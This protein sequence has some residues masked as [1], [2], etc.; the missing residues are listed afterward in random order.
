MSADPSLRGR[1]IAWSPH[2]GAQEAFLSCPVFEVLLEGERGSGK[3]DVLLMD[4]AQFVDRGFGPAWRGVLFRRTYDELKDVIAK[5]EHWFPRIWPDATYNRVEHYWRWKKGEQLFLGQ[6]MRD[7]DYRKRHGHAYT[8]IGWEELTSWPSDSGFRLMMSCSRSSVR[9]I[10]LHVRATTN[11]YGVGHNWVKSRY[12]LPHMRRR[13]ITDPGTGLQR[14]AIFA[15]L[16]QNRKLV[17]ADPNYVSRVSAAARNES[18]RLAWMEGRWDI[19]AGGMLDDVWDGDQNVVPPIPFERIPPSWTIDRSF[20]WGSSKPFAVGWYA[21]SSGEPIRW[22]NKIYGAVRGDVYVIAEWYG[23]TQ[24]R[25]E[26]VRM[27]AG[28]IGRGIVDR[29]DDWGLRGRVRRGPAD[30]SIFDTEPGHTSVAED[31]E[32]KGVSWDPADKGPGSRKQGWEQI[33]KYLKGAHVPVGG[34]PREQP[35]LFVFSTCTQFLETV[36][37]LPRDHKDLDDVDSEAEDHWGDALRYRLRRKRMTVRQTS[38]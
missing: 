24:N 10:P 2:P 31:M 14:V 21:E 26:G 19:V 32:A 27:P 36:P 5:T 15:P 23:C 28:E 4:F 9:G 11:P 8:W 35:G 18:E 38:F 22:Q 13:V 6:F 1:E 34:G 29:E 12:Q 20:D 30:S 25:N 37:T 17:E 7:A 33:R 16:A 3:T